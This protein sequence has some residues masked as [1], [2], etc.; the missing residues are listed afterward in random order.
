ME[1]VS[2]V[3]TLPEKLLDGSKILFGF[4]GVV[5]ILVETYAVFGREILKVPVPWAD[6]VLKL[7]FVWC[8][9]VGSALAFLSDDLISLTLIEDRAK[10]KGNM[11]LFGILKIVQYAAALGISALLVV[12]LFTIVGTQLSTGEATTVLKYPRWV[13]NSGILIGMGLIVAA[14]VGKL[15]GCAKYFKN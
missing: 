9:F 3:K 11:K 2:S 14:S 10:E 1:N 13:L 15:I 7:L 8:I 12:Q 5:M 6:E 4:L